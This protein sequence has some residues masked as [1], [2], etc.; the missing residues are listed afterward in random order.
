MEEVFKLKF[1]SESFVKNIETAVTSVN[2][3]D[4][5][6]KKLAK[7]TEGINLNKPVT[8]LQKLQKLLSAGGGADFS[9]FNKIFENFD[10]NTP[11]IKAFLDTLKNE[12]K[13]AS[14]PQAMK[15]LGSIISQTEK[16]IEEASKK[17]TKFGVA[18]ENAE[19]KH[20]SF[21]AQIRSN[22]LALQ[23]M[24]I[25]G[26]E[27]TEAYRKLSAETS[28]L[29]DAQGDLQGAL[30]KASSDTYKL[31]L[32]LEG[33]NTAIGAYQT[34]IGVLGLTGT[35]TEELQESINKLLAVQQVAQG[36]QEISTFLTNKEGL[37]LE[38]KTL[39][40]NLSARSNIFLAE[41]QG[42][43]TAAQQ[44]FNKA[45]LASG[46]G[47]A[48]VA[49]GLLIANWDKVEEALSGVSKTQKEYNDLQKESNKQAGE[50]IAQLKVLT[51]TAQSETLSKKERLKAV[52]ELQKQYPNYFGNLTKE[53]ILYGD[54]SKVINEVNKALVARAR[55][56]A[57][58]GK[59]AEIEQK[60]LDDELKAT[61]ELGK[62]KKR[63]ALDRD[64]KVLQEQATLK[65]LAS[66]RKRL[67][68]TEKFFLDK[69]V[70]DKQASAKLEID[71]DK[72]VTNSKKDTTKEI[73]NVYKERKQVLDQALIDE[74]NST[75]VGL[76]K[77]NSE[78]KKKLQERYESIQKDL[79]EGKL[80]KLEADDLRKRAGVL[81]SKELEDAINAYK[82]EQEEKVIQLNK[83]IED[84]NYQYAESRI[85]NL[86]NDIEKE[87][88]LLDF[89]YKKQSKTLLDAKAEALKKLEADY[90]ANAIQIEEYYQKKD[91]IEK[92]YNNISLENQTKYTNDTLAIQKKAFEAQIQIIEEQASRLNTSEDRK[93][94]EAILI[95]A[96]KLKNREI[97]FE[98]YKKNVEAIQKK[99]NQKY[100][101][102]EIAKDEEELKAIKVRQK[103]LEGA[104][105]EA[106]KKEL[107]N[108]NKQADVLGKDI[109]EKKTQIAENIAKDKKN[110]L[111]A[112]IFGVSNE[113]GQKIADQFKNIIF[114]VIDVIKQRNQAEIDSYDQAIK[115]QERRVSDATK[116]AENGNTEYLRIEEERLA[117]LEAKR[118][119]AAQRQLEIDAAVQASQILVA[120]AGAVAQIAQGGAVGV[121]TGIA[122]IAGAVA[123]GF[124]LLNQLSA[125]RPKFYDGTEY[126]QLG[127]NPKGKDTI[128]IMAHE[129]ERIVPSYI[130]EK[131]KG[132]KNED[133][134]KLLEMGGMP[135]FT[136]EKPTPSKVVA[137]KSEL[138]DLKKEFKELKK[139]SMM[140]VEAFKRFSV[141]FSVDEK[142]VHGLVT[143]VDY[144][145]FKSKNA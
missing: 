23:A 99:Y 71:E 58:E 13:K 121:I 44:T 110:N 82:K 65:T 130:N 37:A 4:N 79:S 35:E 124:S 117:Q 127:N 29:I 111:F 140:Q 95:E 72:K 143:S 103:K 90:D 43:A 78:Y 114:S 74:Q 1:D 92:A 83:N 47:A 57:I 116:I 8:E 40:T 86:Q 144:E 55:A 80:S 120:I 75:L 45:L 38:A 10:K 20:T 108:L 36:F 122:T 52:D 50:D 128:P 113:D 15:T 96:N 94:A 126:L 53:Q 97:T 33:I 85:N 70:K 28:D 142:G 25:A 131:L 135:S 6:M 51:T 3:L 12:L 119:A 31:D 141:N 101:E 81:S 87:T 134:P 125:A 18:S 19:K 7:D 129:G 84:L 9:E 42:L 21:K 100:L 32:G 49:I 139:I 46:I 24:A 77:I 22:T 62:I 137:E 48:I 16:A 88:Q 98:Q 76:E 56:Q 133:L 66:N 64:L 26:E 132:I 93:A 123:T 68:D 118:E 41:T 27:N 112:L 107:E 30:K 138:S 11:K 67:N 91:A 61:I 105:D 104:T 115:L 54:L 59:I 39:W 69:L 109:A 136:V 145:K 34:Y 102:T 89:N 63:D 17:T 2:D 14:D 106:S 73:E 60:K 5:T